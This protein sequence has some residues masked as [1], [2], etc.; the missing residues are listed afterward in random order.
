VYSP[1]HRLRPVLPALAATLFAVV[2]LPELT[3]SSLWY[4]ELFSMGVA[5][6][7]VGE[8]LR[9][10]IADHTNPPL[11]YVLL[12]AWMAVGGDAD[13]WVR[14]LP[15]LFAILLG[16]AMVWLV[17]EARVGKVAGALAIAIAAASPLSVDLATE[18]RAYSLLALLACL[19]LAAALRLRRNDTR[20]SFA[21]LTIVNV[22][23]VHTHYFGWLTVGAEVATAWLWWNRD[24]A[25][26]VSRSAALALLAFLPWGAAVVAHA[27]SN[28]APLRNVGWIAAP[29]VLE[30]VWLLRDLTGRWHASA[31]NNAWL[32]LLAV[33]LAALLYA[34]FRPRADRPTGEP[35]A[36][37]GIVALLVMAAIAMPLAMYVVSLTTGHSIWVQRY[38]VGAA[39]PTALLAAVAVCA[40]PPRRWPVAALA[41]FLWAIGAF[42]AVP[43]RAPTKFDWRRFAQRI[44]LAP[45]SPRD[46]YAL[47]AF[48]GAPLLRYAGL[49]MRVSVI[50]SLEAL[51]AGPA[52]LVYR[53]E[54]FPEAGPADHL[55]AVGFTVLAALSAETAGQKIV[56]VRISR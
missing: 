29:T 17:E 53:R 41:G 31:V 20:D 28:P 34:T 33:A 45:G 51:P 14:L 16:A 48:T 27:T 12:K 52:W 38:L 24:A 35:A 18:V 23:L 37:R 6:L 25:R 19:S 39:A 55:K 22:A 47:E 40:L 49:G 50:P 4:D 13:A 30:P 21:L 5:G 54:S 26:R 3:R 36:D 2:R 32:G 15:C 43:Q 9:R 8:S 46:V 56:A 1:L 44:N 10:I 7:P 11:F 42:A